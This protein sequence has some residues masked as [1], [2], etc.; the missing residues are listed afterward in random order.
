MSDY[1]EFFLGSRADI[2]QLELFEISHPDF[3]QTYRFV[4]NDVD[5]VTVDLGPT[6]LAVPFLYY[7][8]RLEQ[9]GARDDL[10][11]SI[12]IDIGDLG[13]I[14][15][16]EIDQVA[17]AGGFLIKPAVRYWVY[18]SDILTAPIFGPIDLEASVFNLTDQGASFEAKAPALN[19]VKT[20]ERYTL[21]RFPPMRG[22]L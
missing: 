7:P 21:E 19:S 18:R 22:F 9:L 14:V 3:S 11:S 16:S 17:N 8:A 5:G 2:V 4:R 15:P 10:E 13:E 20:G 6:E 1:A 12:R